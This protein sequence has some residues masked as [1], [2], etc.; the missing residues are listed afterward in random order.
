MER[1][2]KT[3][4]EKIKGKGGGAS[5][6]LTLHVYINFQNITYFIFFAMA[7]CLKFFLIINS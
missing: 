4:G 6:T 1:G 5:R 7:N 2:K 3:K